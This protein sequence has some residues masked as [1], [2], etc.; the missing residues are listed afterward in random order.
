MSALSF[1]ASDVDCSEF[2]A[3]HAG[4]T[5]TTHSKLTVESRAE[6][7]IARIL[8]QA[9]V[10]LDHVEF[11]RVSP[12]LLVPLHDLTIVEAAEV[13][14]APFEPVRPGPLYLETGFGL[15]DDTEPVASAERDN[16]ERIELLTEA[17]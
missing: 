11:V 6:A 17:S 4:P 2:V 8:R 1:P 10:V 15:I 12:I 13:L 3:S 16:R 5:P 14:A 9:G 7:L